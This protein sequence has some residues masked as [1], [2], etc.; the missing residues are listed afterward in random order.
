MIYKAD[1]LTKGFSYDKAKQDIL[2]ELV[3]HNRASSLEV[4]RKELRYTLPV[5]PASRVKEDPDID[6]MTK[7]F[8]AIVLNL[9]TETKGGFNL[10]TKG[11]QN[12]NP[13]VG[14]QGRPVG[15]N[16]TNPR[17]GELR[18]PTYLEEAKSCYYY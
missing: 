9:Y 2:S 11:N 17:N 3:D 4:I 5:I 8:K 7:S 6:R 12:R 13:G 10:A 15:I 14:T 18:G 1:I 16:L